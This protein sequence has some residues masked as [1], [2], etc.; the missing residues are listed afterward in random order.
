VGEQVIEIS[1]IGNIRPNARCVSAN[2]GDRRRQLRLPAAGHEY[3]RAFFHKLMGRGKT[4]P[5][6]PACDQSDFCVQLAHMALSP[7][8]SFFCSP[9]VGWPGAIT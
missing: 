1:G 4:D 9:I 5:T 6:A 8:C 7:G 2:L 3:E